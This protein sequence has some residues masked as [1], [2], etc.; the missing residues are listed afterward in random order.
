MTDDL[1][2]RLREPPTRYGNE[3]QAEA[4]IRRNRE[5][6]ESADCID[7]LEKDKADMLVMF[8]LY[9]KS[10]AL[11]NNH[12]AALEAELAAAR[13]GRVTVKPLVWEQRTSGEHAIWG[14]ETYDVWVGS[15]YHR[16]EGVGDDVRLYPTLEAA[17]AA[18]QADYDAITLT[19]TPVDDS[20]G[21]DPIAKP[22]PADIDRAALQRPKVRALVEA[23]QHIKD[24]SDR[25]DSGSVASNAAMGQL[26]AALAALPKG[27]E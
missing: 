2:R 25:G 21:A 23:A 13:A 3:T 15:D 17:K 27:G 26:F 4:T 11:L 22:T 16:L 12:I 19:P 18:A 1:K 20:A 14:A 24:R 7:A 10:D 6:A 9:I 8:A 5:R